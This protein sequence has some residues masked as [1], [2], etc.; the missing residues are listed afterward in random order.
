[1]HQHAHELI[2]ELAQ[3]N[4]GKAIDLLGFIDCDGRYDHA[5]GYATIFWPDFVIYE[6]CIFV[7]PPDDANF[8]Q[9]KEVFKGDLSETEKMINHRHIMDIF[10]NSAYPPTR[11]ILRHLG[12]V[13][14]SMWECRIQRDFPEKRV[15]V[16]FFEDDNASL[17]DGYILTVYQVRPPTG[18]NQCALP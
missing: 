18:H 9:W 13:L 14:K 1:M 10:L 6:G 12:K 8:R 7:R 4:G 15:V 16:E 17:V 5:I 2:P 3:W 11:E